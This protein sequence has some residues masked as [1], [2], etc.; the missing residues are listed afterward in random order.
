MALP[1]QPMLQIKSYIH[2]NCPLT[3]PGS[4]NDLAF[5]VNAIVIPIK[6]MRVGGKNLKASKCN[7][8]T[9]K[10]EQAKTP[11]TSELISNE[12]FRSSSALGTTA[13]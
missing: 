10:I 11:A 9:V 8:L 3:D 7:L 6:F 5:T 13:G 12:A 2:K 4:R 1:L